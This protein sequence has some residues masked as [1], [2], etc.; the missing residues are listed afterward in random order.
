M[1]LA[2]GVGACQFSTRPPG[3]AQKDDTA[4]QAVAVSFYRALA[5]GDS[6]ALDSITFGAAT[7]LLAVGHSPPSLIAWRALG[8]IPERRTQAPG[9]RLVRTDIRPDGDFA[10]VRVVIAAQDPTSPSEFE[11]TDVLTVARRAGTWRIAHVVFG[12]W[13]LRTAP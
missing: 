5:K 1:C 12:P 6:P 2:L 11:A 7:A 4:L 3:E 10:V 9:V 13:R 8:S